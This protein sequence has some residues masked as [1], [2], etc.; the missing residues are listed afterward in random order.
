MGGRDVGE[1]E[2]FDGYVVGWSW[3]CEGGWCGRG[4]VEGVFFL[5][6]PGFEGRF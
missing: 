6:G 5:E 4:D 1:V 2:E 3:F